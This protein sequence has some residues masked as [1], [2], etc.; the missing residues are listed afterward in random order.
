MRKIVN[1]VDYTKDGLWG[2]VWGFA[3]TTTCEAL[4]FPI[5]DIVRDSTIVPIGASLWH[6]VRDSVKSKIEQL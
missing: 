1:F 2:S 3:W 4:E 5:S 6:C